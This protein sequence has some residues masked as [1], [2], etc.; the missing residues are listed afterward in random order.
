VKPP[1]QSALLVCATVWCLAIV[2]APLFHLT[3]VYLFF[4]TIC[5]QILERSWHLNGVPLGL[6]IRCTSISL[7]FLTGLL[8]LRQPNVRWLKISIV[9]TAL[10][11]FFALTVLDSE[12]LRSLS[13]L[14]LGA[15]A[16][17][18]VRTGVEEM[19]MRLRTAHEPM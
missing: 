14:L 10:E 18:I 1:A 11:W 12:T 15:T 5:H 7:G 8:L 13:G 3:P 16:A 6:C 17:P 4:S 9:I 2:A 19:L